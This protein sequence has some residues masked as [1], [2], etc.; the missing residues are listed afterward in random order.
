MGIIASK[1]MSV[2]KA[3]AESLL[4]HL[5]HDARLLTGKFY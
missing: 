4:K 5:K 3:S 1:K 2:L